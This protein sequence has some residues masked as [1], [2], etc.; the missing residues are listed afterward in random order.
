MSCIWNTKSYRVIK[1][2]IKST[3]LSYVQNNLQFCTLD[4]NLMKNKLF[5]FIPKESFA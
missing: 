3:V 2:R 4:I 5:D 1:L